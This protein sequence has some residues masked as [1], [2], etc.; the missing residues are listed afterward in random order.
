[1]TRDII[2]HPGPPAD[3][4][5]IMAQ[6][7]GRSLQ[8]TLP[9]G[10]ILMEAVAE[11]M[12]AAGADSGAM[13]LDGLVMGPYRFVGPGPSNDGIHAAWYSAP[14]GGARA[15]ITHGTAMVGRRDGAW[16]LHCHAAWEGKQ[17]LA[18]HLLPHEVTLAEDATVTLHA[19]NGACFDVSMNPETQ[20]PI[21]HPTGGQPGN[22][23]IAKLTP[24]KDAHTAICEIAAEAGFESAHVY[25][26]G[27]LI[28]ARFAEGGDMASPISEVF[29]LPGATTGDTTDLPVHCVDPD[30]A[31][32][33]GSLLPDGG[34]VCVTFELLLMDAKT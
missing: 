27:S 1:M 13:V 4:P 7:T 15:T 17:P 28:G 31:Q 6:G 5:W 33:N 3:Q 26:V 18:G 14:R 25:G 29:V 12:D 2:R 24:H 21:F 16:W 23:V 34:P 30:D 11:A 19:I 8:I 22:A 32:F 9:K 10:K 20:F